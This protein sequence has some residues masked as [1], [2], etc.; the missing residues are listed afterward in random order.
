ME[1]VVADTNL[2]VRAVM[3]DDVGQ[4]KRVARLLKSSVVVIL[5][6]VFMEAEW[7]LRSLYGQSR[8][9]IA[10]AFRDLIALDHTQIDRRRMVLGV[11]DAYE[12]GFD[13]ADALHHACAEGLEVKT[14]DRR[15]VKRGKREGWKVSLV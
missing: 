1:I 10:R 11:I 15:F 8:G 3:G 12:K 6:T 2:L 4:T 14:F 9:E 5:E 7:V 13:F